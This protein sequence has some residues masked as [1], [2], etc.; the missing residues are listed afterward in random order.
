MLLDLQKLLNS[1]WSGKLAGW[2][3]KIISDWPI[4]VGNICQQARVEK[5]YG[6][7]I[8]LGVYD[9][10][11]MQ[12]LHLLSNMIIRKINAH[13]EG[14]YIKQIR[15]KYVQKHEFSHPK[16][17]Q[18]MEFKAYPLSPIETRALKKIKDLELRTAMH[19]FLTRCHRENQ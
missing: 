19:N 10:C 9:T 7:T 18:I 14:D 8:L 4:I 5:V 15:L 2:Q 6:D 11:W 16:D 1:C 17:P 3:L 12:Q 13:L